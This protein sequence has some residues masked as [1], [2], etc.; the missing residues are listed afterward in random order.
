MQ[1]DYEA[2][3]QRVQ[4]LSEEVTALKAQVAEQLEEVG[5]FTLI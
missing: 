3:R 5:P 4:E 2:E 1:A